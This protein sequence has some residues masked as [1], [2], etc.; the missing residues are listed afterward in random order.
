[1]NK[2]GRGERGEG[3]LTADS[4]VKDLGH[5]HMTEGAININENEETCLHSYS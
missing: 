4:L 1:M 2:E 3:G 5:H